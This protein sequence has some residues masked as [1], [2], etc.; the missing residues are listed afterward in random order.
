MTIDEGLQELARQQYPRKVDVVEG[1]MAQ[2]RQH[3]YL[4]HVHRVHT[5]QRIASSAVAAVLLAIVVS[6]VVI[7]VQA[8]NDAGLG[9]MI[10]QVQD[11][12]YYGSAVEEPALN[13]I[14]CIY[15]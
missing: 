9:S 15:E 1:V 8:S 11:Y 2:V 7:R 10:A 14:E 5:W 6:T 13:P 4:Q 3:P 12:G